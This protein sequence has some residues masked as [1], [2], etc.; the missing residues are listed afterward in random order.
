MRGRARTEGRKIDVDNF[1]SI[2]HAFSLVSSE[3]LPMLSD[4][5]PP[6]PRV[7]PRTCSL[8]GTRTQP[9]VGLP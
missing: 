4:L 2:R 9:K 5:S 8:D 1:R 6:L 7:P 3:G